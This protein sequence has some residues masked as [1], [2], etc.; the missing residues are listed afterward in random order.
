MIFSPIY[1]T[2]QKFTVYKMQFDLKAKILKKHM[3]RLHCPLVTMKPLMTFKSNLRKYFS[4]CLRCV[5]T[6]EIKERK[7]KNSKWWTYYGKS[8]VGSEDNFDLVGGRE[9][10]GRWGEGM[11]APSET[12]NETTEIDYFTPWRG[13]KLTQLTTTVRLSSGFG[14]ERRGEPVNLI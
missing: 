7:L 10:G 4:S 14:G 6:V 1:L 5:A 9:G 12:A 11:V 3:S 8:I 2:Q 13:R